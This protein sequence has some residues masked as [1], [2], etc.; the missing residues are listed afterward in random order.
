MSSE[1]RCIL[2]TRSCIHI[3]PIS[4]LRPR[5]KNIIVLPQSRQTDDGRTVPL[6]STAAAAETLNHFIFTRQQYLYCAVRVSSEYT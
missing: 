2:N 6:G 1:S 4:E 3:I 5:Y